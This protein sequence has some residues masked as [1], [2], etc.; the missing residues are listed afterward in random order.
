LWELHGVHPK[1]INQE[2]LDLIDLVDDQ[3]KTQTPEISLRVP[4]FSKPSKSILPSPVV[5][6]NQII[7]SAPRERGAGFLDSVKGVLSKEVGALPSAEGIKQ[8]AQSGYGT[9]TGL[10]N[11]AL[12]Y[13]PSFRGQTV[14]Q[15]RDPIRDNFWENF[16]GSG[17]E[18][19]AVPSMPSPSPVTQKTSR[20]EEAILTQP[21]SPVA[22]QPQVSATQPQ[23]ITKGSSVTIQHK[24]LSFRGMIEEAA[25]NIAVTKNNP[26]VIAATPKVFVAQPVQ[27]PARPAGFQALGVDPTPFVEIPSATKVPAINEPV[28]EREPVTP[29]IYCPPIYRP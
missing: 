12:G 24:P 28:I 19:Q 20:R 18:K 7:S 13:R 3:I 21:P 4:G 5:E 2:G 6:S 9:V 22:M 15:I 26:V 16:R 25:N 27:T 10:L 8:A 17:S 14:E 23:A 29:A 1:E 11:K